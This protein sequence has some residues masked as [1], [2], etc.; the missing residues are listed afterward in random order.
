MAP[1]KRIRL[2]AM[3]GRPKKVASKRTKT[4]TPPTPAPAP[5]PPRKPARVGEK[6]KGSGKIWHTK[7]E[8]AIIRAVGATRQG[9][10]IDAIDSQGIPFEVRESKKT[11]KYRLQKDVHE[12]LCRRDGYYLL[13]KGGNITKMFANDVTCLLKKGDWSRDRN[14]PYKYLHVRDVIG[15]TG[16]G[17]MHQIRDENNAVQFYSEYFSST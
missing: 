5:A 7:N 17:L 9:R 3:I 12:E 14:Y 11:P 8:H 1:S 10:G 13:K 6:Q 16:T 15:L 4:P 2:L